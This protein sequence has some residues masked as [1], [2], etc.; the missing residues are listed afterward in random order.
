M[1]EIKKHKEEQKQ[2]INI[3]NPLFLSDAVYYWYEQ[4]LE[5]K[6]INWKW[7]FHYLKDKYPIFSFSEQQ[8]LSQSYTTKKNVLAIIELLY[9]EEWCNYNDKLVH[10]TISDLTWKRKDVIEKLAA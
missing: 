2:D 8:I 3:M 5:G 1:K 6:Q 7:F 9:D 4:Q 10:R